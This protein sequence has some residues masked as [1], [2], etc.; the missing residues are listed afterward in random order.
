MDE[1]KTTRLTALIISVIIIGLSFIKIYD[2]HSVGI[3]QGCTLACR[4][5]YPF[6]HAN[7]M[8]ALVNAWC[9]LSVVF[10]YDNISRLRIAFAYLVTISAPAFSLEP[11]VGLSGV[12]YVLFGSI[13]FEVGR[14]LY[15]QLWVLFYLCIGFFFPYTNAW[16]HLYCYACGVVAAIL[17]KPLKIKQ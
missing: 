12:V 3:Y 8:H 7:L 15:Y 4:F 2:W 11:T 16:L 6:F 1:K 13:S 9:L 17:N 10:V 5:I 14:R